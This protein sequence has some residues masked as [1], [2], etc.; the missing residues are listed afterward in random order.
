MLPRYVALTIAGDQNVGRALCGLNTQTQEV[1]LLPPRFV[2]R[3]GADWSAIV[4]DF[5]EYPVCFRECV[6]YFIAS[7]VHHQ[8]WLQDN[9][10][11]EHPLF[12]SRMWRARLHEQHAAQVLPPVKNDLKVLRPVKKRKVAEL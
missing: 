11:A 3:S 2:P 6:P 7:V 8:Q 5:T 12:T 4:P 10:P 1:T 9:L